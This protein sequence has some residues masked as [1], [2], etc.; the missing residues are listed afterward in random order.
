MTRRRAGVPRV[1]EK[2]EQAQIITF[3]RTLGGEVYVLGTHRRR[4][5][6]QGTM[7][8]PGLPDLEAFLPSIGDKPGA[9]LFLKVECK[10]RGGKLRPAQVEYQQLAQ[11]SGLVH[12]V[13]GLDAVI[14]WALEA[15][16]ITAGQV[17]HYRL[18]IAAEADHA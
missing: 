7:Q 3:L 2:V 17:P 4:G 13:G 5:D 11:L 12:I 14:A 18:P 15:G 10:A 6:F 1:L 8:T 9:W 16:Y